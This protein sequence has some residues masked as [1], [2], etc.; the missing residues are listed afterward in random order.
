M[1]L[2][3]VPVPDENAFPY[4]RFRSRNIK[5]DYA[6]ERHVTDR[7]TSEFIY[8]IWIYIEHFNF[9]TLI[10]KKSQ[11]VYD[12]VVQIDY[13]FLL[14]KNFKLTNLRHNFKKKY[15]DIQE[16]STMFKRVYFAWKHNQKIITQK[17]T[18][19]IP[20][21]QISPWTFFEVMKKWWITQIS[22]ESP[23]NLLNYKIIETW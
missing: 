15:K 7:K 23:S 3:R 4:G 5:N 10:D 1:G 2:P 11:R 6:A 13:R 12:I 16:E 17:Y 18:R 19:Y 21:C 14:C 22:R 20:L 8:K 9:A